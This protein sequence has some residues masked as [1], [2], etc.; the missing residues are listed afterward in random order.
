MVEVDFTKANVGIL[1]TACIVIGWKARL[2]RWSREFKRLFAFWAVFETCEML[3]FMYYL[4]LPRVTTSRNIGI[5]L[6]FFFNRQ[7]TIT[8]FF[9]FREK[10]PRIDIDGPIYLAISPFLLL[11]S[12]ATVQQ[13]PNLIESL[14]FIQYMVNYETFRPI[15]L[16]QPIE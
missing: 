13:S 4:P 6:Y 3:S 7:L 16:A 14:N 5:K 2:A 10:F 1:T 12:V 15:P 11:S 8:L 9:I